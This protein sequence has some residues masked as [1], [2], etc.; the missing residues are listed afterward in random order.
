[1]M[2]T[3]PRDMEKGGWEDIGGVRY[4]TPEPCADPEK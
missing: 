2:E 1:M 3:Q 4:L